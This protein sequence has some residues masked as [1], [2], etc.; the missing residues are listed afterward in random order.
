[1]TEPLPKLL[2]ARE[3]AEML[4][5]TSET[6]LRWTRAGELPAFKLPSGAIRYRAERVEE[7]LEA[8]ATAMRESPVAASEPEA[9]PSGHA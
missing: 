6:V 8:R 4:A 7:W 9:V 5:V 3:V 2:T 1:M